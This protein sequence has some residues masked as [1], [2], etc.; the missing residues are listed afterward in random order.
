MFRVKRVKLLLAALVVVLPLTLAVCRT[1]EVVRQTL[2]TA[3]AVFTPGTFTASYGEAGTPGWRQGPLVL[4]VSFS[5]NQITGIDVVSHGE[6]L[7]G[8]GWFFRAYPAVPDQILVRQSTVE[9]DAFTGATRTKEAFVRAVN[10]AIVQAGANPADLEPRFIDGPIYGD[11]FVPGFHVITVPAGTMDIA[12]APLTA[13]TPADRVMLYSSDVDMTLRVSVA[14]N[15]FHVYE[16]GAAGLGQG[17]GGHGEPVV[18]NPVGIGDGTWGGWWFSQVAPQQINDRQATRNLDIRTGAERSAAAV[19]WGVEQA[20]VAAGGNPAALEP[21]QV[22]PVQRRRNPA[23]PDAPFFVPG[24][25]TVTV[26][27]YAGDIT[28]TVTLDRALIRRIVVDSHNVPE[29]LWNQV[30]PALR[31]AIYETQNLEAV[32]LIAGAEA[33]SGAIIDAV[34]V[35][36]DMADPGDL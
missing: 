17:T 20:L 30:W 5:E 7:H 35:A 32:D 6:T 28:L 26:P 21:R 9:I 10:D 22:P 29:Y 3:T 18:L 13:D 12:G 4:N 19:V 33:A 31:D 16:G 24:H 27:G 2:P 8:S 11:L 1:Q 36:L 15:E 34:R 14:R 25:Y 23:A